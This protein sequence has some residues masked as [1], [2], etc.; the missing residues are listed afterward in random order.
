MRYKNKCGFTLAELLVVVA[1]IG[2]LVSVSIP[3]FASQTAKA[4]LA[5]DQANMRSAKAAAV[6]EYLLGPSQE[7]KIYYYDASSG[8]VKD[9]STGIKGY[10]QST[11]NV[12]DGNT[13]AG[14][15]NNGKAAGIV[16][17]TVKA[18]GTQ[19]V[20]WST[21]TLLDDSY[22]AALA[23]YNSDTKDLSA[24]QLEE[25]S[26]NEFP[27]ATYPKGVYHTDTL[28]WVPTVYTITDSTGKSQNIMVM[29]AYNKGYNNSHSAFAFAYE[30]TVYRST[31]KAWNG[32][33]DN[34]GINGTIVGD[35]IAGKTTKFVK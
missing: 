2:V 5:A 22:A 10:G 27:T 19:S 9:S 31:S 14:I 20:T 1:I 3:I 24:Y 33:T 13:D 29:V 6:T 16:K 11:V 26:V 34:S 23:A 21:G 15:P 4:K 8:T 7:D 28:V 25:P 12:K 17:V 32:Q 35:T 18:D 30:G